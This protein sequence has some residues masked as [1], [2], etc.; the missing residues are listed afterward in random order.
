MKS[1][2]YYT[3]K[4]ISKRPPD[5][6][7]IE[8]FLLFSHEKEEI[9]K[10]KTQVIAHKQIS[11]TQKEK[12]D[13][14]TKTKDEFIQ[15][16]SEKNLIN[17]DNR[18]IF[19]KTGKRKLI[20][21][22]K[23]PKNKNNENKTKNEEELIFP[24]IINIKLLYK[25]LTPSQIEEIL[26]KVEL[27]NKS[28]WIEVMPLV[29]INNTTIKLQL[30]DPDNKN[31]YII[32]GMI[33][34]E[35]STGLIKLSLDSKI[36]IKIYIHK[37]KINPIIL[38]GLN[39]NQFSM[40]IDFIDE[41]EYKY[42]L[43]FDSY[44]VLGKDICNLLIELKNKY[45]LLEI[46]QKI[47]LDSLYNKLS[48]KEENNLFTIKEDFFQDDEDSSENQKGE[49]SDYLVDNVE[50]ILSLTQTYD[51]L[52][53][54]ND[55]N[56]YNIF[57]NLNKDEK[58][59]L[60]KFLRRNNKWQN[61]YKLFNKD[62]SEIDY[63][64]IDNLDKIIVSLSEKKLIS[65][66]DEVISDFKN[67]NNDKLFEYLYFLSNDDIKK[68]NTDLINI[69]KNLK[70]SKDKELMVLSPYI[71]E[72][73]INNPFY[74]LNNFIAQSDK[75][76]ILI[77][78]INEISEK[79]TK[80]NFSQENIS[81]IKSKKEANINSIIPELNKNNKKNNY[82]EY[83]N[84]SN[85]KNILLSNKFMIGNKIKLIN[86]VLSSINKYLNEKESS[87]LQ[88]FLSQNS[89]NISIYSKEISLKNI[90]KDYSK[91]FYC[92]NKKFSKIIDVTSRLFFFYTSCKDL[93]D[94]EKEFYDLEKYEQYCCHS[95][96]K[97]NRI[98]KDKN[99]F[100]L[101]DALYQIQNSYEI[102]SKF[103]KYENEFP[104]FINS[105]FQPLIPFL[106]KVINDNLYSNFFQKIIDINTL[107]D[108]DLEELYEALTQNLLKNFESKDNNIINYNKLS[109]ADK[110]KSEYI[111]AEI[112]NSYIL[113]LEKNKEF[114]KA[115]L[116]YMYLL[117]C[118]DNLY[119]LEQRGSIYHR[120]ITNFN[121][122]LK[123]KKN[124]IDILNICIEYDIR[125]YAVIKS[126]ELIKIKK[127]YDKFKKQK[128]NSKSKKLKKLYDSLIIYSFK[129]INDDF[130]L[131]KISKEIKGQGF[132]SSKTGRIQFKL[133]NNKYSTTDIVER[134]ALKFYKETEKLIG[135]QGEN[136]VLPA[137]YFLLF[138]EEIFDDQIPLV[139]QSKYQGSPLDFYEKDF[140]ITRKAKID[141]KLERI[142]KYNKIDLINHIKKTYQAKRGIKNPCILWDKYR[143]KE[144]ILIKI[145]VAIGPEKLVKIFKIILNHGLKYVKI[146]MP[147]LFLWEE[148]NSYYA[149]ENSIKIVEVKSSKDILSDSQKFWLKILYEIGINVE[150][151]YVK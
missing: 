116:F 15:K 25:G 33:P 34:K 53:D 133:S 32:L 63:N 26:K 71:K 17:N 39:Y 138:W 105:I 84:Y 115:N 104:L 123:D 127:F 40:K 19:L 144:N 132:N 149:K 113:N 122:H 118:F 13:K 146:G 35:I 42:K 78:K 126:G 65:N 37:N 72:C 83:L 130:D 44:L 79:I 136:H 49:L 99:I 135:I 60:L 117:N 31:N 119:I 109:F 9:K 20:S 102:I 139:F 140:Y 147:D 148:K 10:N 68:I 1:K 142:N 61:I 45:S 6:K 41:N 30:L 5:Q 93:N 108:E 81:K 112:T 125:K 24:I 56:Y 22:I 87:F 76:E 14:I 80:F 58:I 151:L 121:R 2:A 62:K 3:K 75:R 150:V 52:F 128:I 98:F 143:N 51:Y 96:D 11:D 100:N 66:F 111:S 131:N 85:F 86:D 120:L 103:N 12:E 67:E 48:D 28:N 38:I 47:F 36:S 43:H 137:I 54:E 92:I 50:K 69:Y 77:K 107:D 59:I 4:K 64:I 124:A 90:F 89:S 27:E 18:Y 145:S 23:N 91:K 74:N 70:Y 21:E 82:N 46:Q 110:F 97:N 134:F 129:E 95:N 8:T 57:I 16:Q 55:K 114:K 106:L 73:F 29:D 7:L 94:I 101:Y 141:E 88:G